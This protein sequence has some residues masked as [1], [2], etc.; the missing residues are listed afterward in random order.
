MSWG[1]GRTGRP[2]GLLS[3]RARDESPSFEVPSATPAQE[4]RASPSTPPYRSHGPPWSTF[5]DICPT[6]TLPGGYCKP[7]TDAPFGVSRSSRAGVNI[8]PAGR[9]RVVPEHVTR[10]VADGCGRVRAC[11]RPGDGGG[12]YCTAVVQP[13]AGAV[14]NRRELQ[15]R[16]LVAAN[17]AKKRLD[18]VT[19]LAADGRLPSEPCPGRDRNLYTSA[20]ALARGVPWRPR[21]DAAVVSGL[22]GKSRWSPGGQ[23]V[24]SCAV[25][26]ARLLSS[27]AAGAD[28]WL[29]ASRNGR[30]VRETVAAEAR[31]RW[32]MRGSGWA[33]VHVGGLGR[34]LR[35]PPLVLPDRGQDLGGPGT[36]WS[37]KLLAIAPSGPSLG[38]N[39]LRRFSKK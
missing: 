24:Q 16:R 6:G 39:H 8:I 14:A 35:R 4:P 25:R 33:N 28:A 26:S 37:I 9:D 15:R 38:R 2:S 23:Q 22:D 21:H 27:P 1:E 20:Y 31:P 36:A 3:G 12:E 5:G 32:A 18:R 17:C 30:G 10:K 34:S 29:V 13:A 7:H 11:T 19:R